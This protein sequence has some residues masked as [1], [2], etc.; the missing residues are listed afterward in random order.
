MNYAEYLRS[1]GANEED[2]KILDVPASRKAFDKMQAQVVEADKKA[3]D[4]LADKLAYEEKVNKW[5][6]ETI[7]PE[8]ERMKNESL[9]AKANEAKALKVIEQAQKDGL[10]EVTEALG[11]KGTPDKKGDVNPGNPDFDPNKYM[12]RE[13]ALTL[14]AKEGKAITTMAKIMDE[15]RRLAL[16]DCDWEE[17]YDAATSSRKPLAQVWQERFKVQ[18]V[19]AT[20]VK[21]A[22]DAH[23]KEIS[24]KARAEERELMASKYGN[25][26]TRPYVPSRHPFTPRKDNDRERQP[27]DSR[28]GSFLD[29]SGDRV[30][31]ATKKVLQ[32]IESGR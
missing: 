25:P 5:H 4:S 32:Q 11:Y 7:V 10:L 19:R 3:A 14:A 21:E 29:R 2:I 27:W 26:D 24:D 15:H 8:Y 9:V 23:D 22:Q 12:T 1:N 13:D 30:S 20:K 6:Q 17:L 28:D 16:P 18:E 31:Q